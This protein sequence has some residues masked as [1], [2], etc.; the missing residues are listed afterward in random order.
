MIL[1]DG[2][3]HSSGISNCCRISGEEGVNRAKA[4]GVDGF[5]LTNH[6]HMGY[7]GGEKYPTL[8]CF[9]KRYVEEYRKVK[10]YGDSVGFRV[11]YGLELTAEWDTSVHLLVYGVDE[12]FI[13]DNLRICYEPLERIYQKVHAAGGILVQAHP[14]RVTPR[15][16][17]LKYL[18][19]VEISCHPHSHYGGPYVDE[20]HEIAKRNGKILTCGGDYHADVPYR[21]QCGIYV[22]EWVQDGKDFAAYL[23]SADPL[24]LRVHMPHGESYDLPYS[25]NKN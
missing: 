13:F 9:A 2:H 8:E 6:Y 19:G 3:A 5:V 23:S 15:L 16:Q 14:Y 20:M 17:D 22:P 10:G 12:S 18:D 1:M 7:V 24:T 11:F 21:P 25:P 4:A